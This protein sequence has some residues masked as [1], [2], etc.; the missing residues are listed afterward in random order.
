LHINRQASVLFVLPYILISAALT[1]QS[2]WVSANPQQDAADTKLTLRFCYEDKQLLPYYTGNTVEV[3]NH[4]GATIEH[5]ERATAGLGINLQLFRM[6]WLRCLKQLEQGEVD[7]LVAGYNA[8][9]AYYTIFPKDPFGQPDP[10]KAINSNALCLTYRYDNNLPEK[11]NNENALLTIARP[12]GYQ[13]LPLPPHAIL[14]DAYSPEQA[15]EL[16]VSG[17]V[18]ATTITCKINSLVDNRLKIHHLPLKILQPPIYYSVGYLMFSQQFYQ[19]YPLI[20]DNLW[21]A[22]P[23]NLEQERYIKYL[24]YPVGF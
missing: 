1:L 20:T 24:A 6:P 9:R 8:E 18:D 4:P 19:Q 21:L 16:V 13:A 2:F 11:M 12:L 7:A 15:L 14:V 10:S 3:P 17:R 23:K 5:L 22:L